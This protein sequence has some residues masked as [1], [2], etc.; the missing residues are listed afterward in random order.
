MQ[1][2]RMQIYIVL[3]QTYVINYKI[4]KLKPHKCVM[5]KHVFLK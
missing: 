2:E 5:F 3:L 1:S 4:T